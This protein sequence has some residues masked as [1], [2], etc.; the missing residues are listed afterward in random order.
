MSDTKIHDRP[1]AATLS[2]TTGKTLRYEQMGWD[3]C[4]AEQGEELMLMY[5]YFDTF[6]MDGAPAYMRR[7]NRDA[8]DFETYLKRAGWGW[9]TQTMTA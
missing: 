9:D 6:G 1:I 7:F 4:A 3:Q 5:R 2:H 8:V